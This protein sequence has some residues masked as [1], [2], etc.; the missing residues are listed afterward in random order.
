MSRR[1]IPIQDDETV[2]PSGADVVVAEPEPEPEPKPESESEA[3]P[4]APSAP[5]VDPMLLALASE[6]DRLRKA[7]DEKDGL[8]QRYIAAHKKAEAEF[9]KVRVRLEADLDRRVAVARGELIGKL[10]PVLDDLERSLD[11]AR[12]TPAFDALVEGVDMVHKTFQARLEDLGVVRYSP[13]GDPF[14]PGVHEAMGVLPAPSAEQNNTVL[15]VYQP[16]YRAGDQVLRPARV[17]V[18]KFGG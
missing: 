16:G 9:A 14:D 18:G 15:Y 7:L 12:K 3:E 17:M 10:F 1:S 13:Q 6:N 11:S 2:E 4:T 5:A 8:L